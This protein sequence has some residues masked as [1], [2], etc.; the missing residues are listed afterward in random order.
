M[1]AKELK[2]GMHVE[3]RHEV[4]EVVD[5]DQIKNRI[6]IEN[7]LDHARETIDCSDLED[8]PQLHIGCESYY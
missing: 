2:M 6:T 3:Y 8:Q 1:Q 4:V 7:P 5:V